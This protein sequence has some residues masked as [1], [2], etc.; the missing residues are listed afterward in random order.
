MDIHSSH[1][2]LLEGLRYNRTGLFS[3]GSV[4]STLHLDRKSSLGFTFGPVILSVILKQLGKH[5]AYRT[6][7]PPPPPPD[8]GRMDI[9]G[10]SFKVKVYYPDMKSV[11]AEP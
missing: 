5:F 10:D 8:K 6:P 4:Q 3:L 7:P 1:F 2:S 9:W 11:F